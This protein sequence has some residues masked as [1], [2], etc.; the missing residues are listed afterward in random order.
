MASNLDGSTDS[1]GREISGVNAALKALADTASVSAAFNL[2]SAR[3][4][5]D[6][7]ETVTRAIGAG[8]AAIGAAAA[9]A[10]RTKSPEDA[11]SLAPVDSRVPAGKI[12]YT[13][14]IKFR[15]RRFGL[16]DFRTA[17]IDS[18]DPLDQDIID[19][20]ARRK[21]MEF[22]GNYGFA[23]DEWD[24]EITLRNIRRGEGT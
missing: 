7:V 20:I 11:V 17:I 8:L 9:L 21:A 1:G 2:L 16:E 23:A 10:F 14:T 22:R 19:G 12:R 15:S 18:D 6:S 3:H 24:V 4:T 5:G 13:V